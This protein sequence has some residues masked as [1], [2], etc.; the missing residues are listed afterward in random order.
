[1]RHILKL[2]SSF[3][4]LLFLSCS[5]VPA[6]ESLGAGKNPEPFKEGDDNVPDN[7]QMPPKPGGSVGIFYN[8]CLD[9]TTFAEVL[10]RT[11]E[12]PLMRM[13]SQQ[14]GEQ[15]SIQIF[16][17]DDTQ[18]YTIAIMNTVFPL[19]HPQKICVL[20]S[21]TGLTYLRQLGIKI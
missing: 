2:T 7:L 15:A 3:L 12:F 5:P 13:P 11:Q 9:G 17:N 20:A 16:V 19:N 1:M 6:Q 4:F 21:G 8:P 18:T 14:H 10:A